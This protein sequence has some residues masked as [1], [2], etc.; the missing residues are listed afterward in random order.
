MNKRRWGTLILAG[1][2]LA[3]LAS[4]GK[5]DPGGASSGSASLPGSASGSE[6]A[7]SVIAPAPEPEHPYSHPLTGEGLD[8]D[9]SA[10][11][12]FAIMF[13]NLRK[14]LPQ[15]GVSKADVIYEIV[16]EGGITRMMAVFQDLEGV[17]DMG[18]IRSARD[19]YVS[20]ALGHDAVYIHAGGSPQAYDA[21][22]AWGVTHID[23]VNGPYGNMC[24]RDPERRKTKGLEHS[25]L[26]SGEKILE[27][28]PKKFAREHGDGFE[29]GW[30]FDKEAPAGGQAAAKL[31]V[32]FSNYKTGYFTYDAEENCY[33]IDQHIDKQ[34]IPYVDGAT[35]EP[36][37]VR[38][39]LVLYTDVGQV[40]GDDKGR[41][42]V[43]TT[44]KGEGLLLRDGQLYEISWERSGEE[45][46]FSFLDR[47][48]K[49]IPLGVGKSYI[50]IVSS[51]A[52]V[53]WE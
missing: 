32:P 6:P 35:G 11:R 48:G 2:L 13:N 4:C 40:K 9:V 8:E 36:V 47:A 19:Y 46:C 44:G 42:T 15:I 16:A 43:R 41:R 18:S 51:G 27:Q 10:G 3:G 1:L 34:D 17:G 7:I 50:N 45:D 38:S 31:T 20:L 26:T 24:W 12:P 52:E 21:F 29:V 30:T 25:L 49:P 23:F 33:L 5:K 22:D 53:E 39:V 28:L 14:A 37:T